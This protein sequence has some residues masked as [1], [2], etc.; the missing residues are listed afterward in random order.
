MSA[1]ESPQFIFVSCQHGAEAA[2]KSELERSHSELRFAF[3]RPGF[4]TY[5]IAGKLPKNFVLHST[6][7]RAYGWSCGK[8]TGSDSQ[9]MVPQVVEML[10]GLPLDQL[11]VW[12]RDSAIPGHRGFEPFP[13]ALAEVIGEEIL[14]ALQAI[15]PE[16]KS[17]SEK[18]ST[19]KTKLKLNVHA[20]PEQIVGD[21]IIVEPGEWWVGWHAAASVSSRWPGGIPDLNRDDGVINR[22]YYKLA[23]AI[24]WIQLPIR[25]QDLCIDLGSAP[26][27][28]AQYLL[29]RG[30]H[31]V[32]V[33]PADLDESIADDPNLLH[34]KMRSKDVPKKDLKGARWLVADL[35]VA[36][37]YTL[38]TVEDFVTNQHIN[39]RGL[40]LTLKLTKWE[41]ADELGELRERVKAWG[42][43]IVK[44][45]QL[46]FNRRE[47]CLAAVKDKM[48]VR[49]GKKPRVKQKGAKSNAKTSNN[50]NK[51]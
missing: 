18:R 6:F 26:G 37:N 43:D 50:K 36:P 23:E 35:N 13:T 31:V 33:D 1:S 5:K 27:G 45:R 3:S 20:K 17:T 8:T 39:L 14:G 41:L 40:I 29:E 30:A 25:K 28:A 32:A 51:A 48:D 11:H 4:L 21:V 49:A 19:R 10:S 38:D 2:C 12:Q 24:K 34:M 44:T 46:A 15:P 16:E 7:A 9:S 22:A 47:V 42:F